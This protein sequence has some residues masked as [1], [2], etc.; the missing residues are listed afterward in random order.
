MLNDEELERA[1]VPLRESA[2]ACASDTS[3][4]MR[5]Q[6]DRQ[7]LAASFCACVSAAVIAMTGQ[8]AARAGVAFVCP[9]SRFAA[10]SRR[11]HRSARALGDA[12][13]VAAVPDAVGRAIGAALDGGV[14]PAAHL[15]SLALGPDS[16]NRTSSSRSRTAGSITA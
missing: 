3:L 5:L 11:T 7:A 12:A 16:P 1:I 4:N 14:P 13:V 2:A 15:R 10:S 8:M 9:V 6:Q